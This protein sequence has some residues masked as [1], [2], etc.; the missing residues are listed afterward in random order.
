ML[1]SLIKKK[2]FFT[3]GSSLLAVMWAK[4]QANNFEFLLNQHKREINSIYG[5]I[6]NFNLFNPYELAQLL[7]EY[8]IDVVVNTVA[9]ASVDQCELQNEL[10]NL[11]NAKLPVLIARACRLS[12]TKLIHISTDHFYG[13]ENKLFTEED[14]LD[15]LNSYAATKY[16]GE[17]GV[18]EEYPLALVCRTNFFGIGPSYKP[19]FSDKIL[20]NLRSKI[21]IALFNDVFF[22]PLV[23]FNLARC[24]HAL[25]DKGCSGIYNISSDNSMSKYEF[26]VALA[27]R[28]G[29]SETAIDS[30]SIASRSDLVL[31]PRG[32]ALSNEKAIKAVGQLF[33]RVECNI[34]ML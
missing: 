13:F 16:A 34:A 29:F 26:G 4:A 19:S 20:N 14:S 32:M 2:V 23:A 8:C 11:L 27:M 6:V 25:V 31:R 1:T 3:G 17:Q 18:L 5:A 30:V 33:G 9:L 7:D 28:Y 12:N 24:A 22:T 10:A 21:P 15:L